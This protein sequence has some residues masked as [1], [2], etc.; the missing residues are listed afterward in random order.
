MKNRPDFL[1]LGHFYF[2]FSSSAVLGHTSS[3]T[4]R[5]NNFFLY[6]PYKWIHSSE[7][8]EGMTK[9]KS[10]RVPVV[11]FIPLLFHVFMF[12]VSFHVSF[13]RSPLAAAD[14]LFCL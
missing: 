2:L 8:H 3:Y 6:V 12:H 10:A 5:T 7:S 13:F 9:K 1:D 14:F 4:F 11:V